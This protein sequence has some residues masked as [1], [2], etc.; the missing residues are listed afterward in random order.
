MENL[1]KS[2][3][4]TLLGL[5]I[6]GMSIYQYFEAGEHINWANMITSLAG[7]GFILSKD[8]N[9]SHTKR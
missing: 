1:L 9:D 3:K 5:L 6:I 7:I 4:T 2:W 8:S